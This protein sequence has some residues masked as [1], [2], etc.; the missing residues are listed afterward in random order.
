MARTMAACFDNF[1]DRHS[2]TSKS[3]SEYFPRSKEGSILVTSRDGAVK[4]LGYT[5]DISTMSNDE[6]IELPFR[7]SSTARSE[8]NLSEARSITER[9]GIHALAIDQAGHIF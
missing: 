3:I 7:R 8:P 4:D 9:L 5:I 6:A 1:D 2:F